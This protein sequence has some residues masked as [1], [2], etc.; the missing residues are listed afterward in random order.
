MG[1]C[2][3]LFFSLNLGLR[4]RVLESLLLFTISLRLL[5]C[6][7]IIRFLAIGFSQSISPSILLYGFF[8]SSPFPPPLYIVSSPVYKSKP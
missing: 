2:Y 8:S 1:L 3:G 5:L 4:R 7:F 6:V